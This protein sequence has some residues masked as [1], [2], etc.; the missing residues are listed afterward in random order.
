MKIAYI[1]H[2]IGGDVQGNL[3]KIDAIVR[4]INLTEPDVVPFVPYYSDCAGAMDDS[5][6]I[7]R[8]RGF[9]NNYQFF[10]RKS[11]D[12]LRLYGDR[13]STGMINEIQW[14]AKYGITIVPMTSETTDAYYAQPTM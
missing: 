9:E 2:P 5:N 10:K 4:H 7:E 13:I 6:P 3:K 12:V 14:A 11:F 8:K 1:A